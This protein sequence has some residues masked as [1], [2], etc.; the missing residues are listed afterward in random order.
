MQQVQ[1]RMQYQQ[2]ISTGGVLPRYQDAGFRVFSDADE[3]GILHFLF[4]VL[5]T[6]DK[7]LVDLGAA[8]LSASNTGNLLVHQGWTGL[9]IEGDA[10]SL[11]AG[12]EE[13]E[14]LGVMPAEMIRAWITEENIDGLIADHV[15]GPVDLLS[16]DID[17]N[18]YWIW[19]AVT[20]ISPRVVVI[21]YQDIIGP[22]RAL[23]IP[24][25]PQFSLDSFPENATHNNYVGASLRA[26]VNLGR[27]KGYRLVAT[28]SYGFNAFFVR[29]DL[30]ADLLPEIPVEA[31]F[32]HPWNEYGHRER[33]P[34]VAD[35]P[36]VEV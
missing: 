20:S 9:L 27:V 2:V 13:F 12:S 15:P 31:G 11:A 28:N 34:L 5:G 21:E 35:L 10:E 18:D 3:D 29:E 7:R 14:S 32:P 26:M 1:L 36:W 6:G 30:A 8:G 16:I 17:G 25:D 22:E 33:W 19:K 4:S 24:Y 23:T